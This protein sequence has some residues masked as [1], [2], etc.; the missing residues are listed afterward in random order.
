MSEMFELDMTEV[1]NSLMKA[2]GSPLPDSDD[3]SRWDL[4]KQRRVYLD[5]DIAYN[6]I[7]LQRLILRWNIED[8]RMEDECKDKGIE[9]LKRDPIWIYI[10]SYGGDLDYMWSLIDTIAASKTPV[11]TV[12]VGIAASAA[13]L[14]FL[15]GHKRFMLPKSHLII[16]E[17][18][19]QLAGDAVK[20]MDQSESY[21]QQLK[22]M[23]DYILERTEIPRNQLMRKRNNDWTIDAQYCLENKACDVII[24]SLDDII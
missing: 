23:K 8:R 21:K 13:S 20:V 1:A 15:A 18:S 7:Q 3:V 17:G 22:Q 19:A 10:M 16:H 24:T 5:D 2:L 4:E 11:Y 6:V 9:P 12:N 14:I